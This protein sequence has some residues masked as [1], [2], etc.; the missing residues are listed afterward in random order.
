MSLARG[1]SLA[2]TFLALFA[3]LCA[4]A[5]TTGAATV[6]N[7]YVYFVLD[8]PTGNITNLYWKG[9]T[10]RELLDQYWNPTHQ[11]GPF[12]IADTWGATGYHESAS[13]LTGYAET[14]DGLTAS[15]T[16]PGYGSKTLDIRWGAGGM[17]VTC[18]FDLNR[19]G[20]FIGGLWNPGGDHYADYLRI[21]PA[22]GAPWELDYVYPGG[23]RHIYG[24]ADIA[25][26]IADRRYDE[27]FGYKSPAFYQEIA[28]GAS[29]D[30]PRVSLPIGRS[31]VEFALTTK[32][33]FDRFASVAPPVAEA[34]PAQSVH[35]GSPV[36]LD[37]SGS[38]DPGGNVPLT[39]RWTIASAPAGSTAVLSGDT[40]VSPTFTPDVP[41]DYVFQLVVTNRFGIASLPDTVTIGT[42][43][44]A[45]VAEAGPDQAIVLLGTT[46][47]LG[48]GQSYDPDGD[49][50]FFEWSFVS[51]P[52]GSAATLTGAGTA[53]PSFVADAHGSYVVRLLVRDPWT[54]GDPDTVTA[55]LENVKP[56]AN[57]GASRSVPVGEP[58]SLDGSG[59]GD[60][61]GDPLTFSW[62]LASLPA[63]SSSA[64]GNATA[65]VAGF[66]PD[67][68]GTYVAQLI[69]NDGYASGDPS[70]VQ[71]L[72][73]S[74]PNAAIDAVRAIQ[75]AVM[76]LPDS[77]FKNANMRNTLINKLNAVV[78]AV[79]EARHGDALGH[80]RDDVL[81]KTNGCAATGAQ[82]RNDWITDCASQ[83]QV[84]P[85][86]NEAIWI[87]EG[88]IP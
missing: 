72:A 5:T 82:D 51:V 12:R 83:A 43:N 14:P 78:A 85:L 74:T 38:R 48:A 59:S 65:P 76:L 4:G 46:V 31:T 87:L 29:I 16:N 33:G 24:G 55:S 10:N 84:H 47:N 73:F 61:N 21:Y 28:A 6:N 41:G 54:T 57:A 15:F 70:T 53:T 34:G 25:I 45:P 66:V 22:G 20:L 68:P 88:L 3:V 32:E 69:V 42:T 67:L 19:E 2:V 44:A 60:A 11:E 13:T 77:A 39:Y 26:G 58:V 49:D 30:G 80:L 17:F 63:N 75:A 37:G 1:R 9:G 50:I 79:G 64:I 18:T 40:A 23:Y 35:A 62:T 71:V 52:A 81:G 86:V 8:E 27:M 36:I 56:V 7:A